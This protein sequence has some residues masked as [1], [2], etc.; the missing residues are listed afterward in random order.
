M[1]INKNEGVQKRFIRAC[2]PR[3]TYRSTERLSRLGLQTLETCRVI[4]DLNVCYKL[5]NTVLNSTLTG[6]ASSLFHITLTPGKKN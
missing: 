3:M 5:L 2:L 4:N 1:D 6:I